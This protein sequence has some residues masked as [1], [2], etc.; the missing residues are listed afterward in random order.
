MEHGYYS[1]VSHYG[2]FLFREYIVPGGAKGIQIYDGHNLV[3][4]QLQ[5]DSDFTV[6]GYIYPYYYAVMDCNL[7]NEEYSIVKFLIEK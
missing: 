5:K 4:S 3:C 7:D 6:I 1:Y 2:E